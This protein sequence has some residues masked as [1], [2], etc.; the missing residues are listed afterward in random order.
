MNSN[1]Y[2]KYITSLV[3]FMAKN[4]YTVK[5]FPK[6]IL[7]NEH[8]DEAF[9]KTGY[10]DP[11]NKEV[12]VFTH[13]RLAKDVLRSI[14]HELI[15]HKQNI[16]GRLGN[17][18]YNGDRIVD[19]KRLERLEIEAYQKGNIGFRSWTESEQKKNQGE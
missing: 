7:T 9:G 5:P 6:I 2:R 14:A 16:E 13:N 10:Y 11:D 15:H 4:G 1:Q 8:Q 18:A 19:D 12:V 3:H 17:R